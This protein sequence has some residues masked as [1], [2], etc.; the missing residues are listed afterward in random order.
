MRMSVVDPARKRLSL[1]QTTLRARMHRTPLSLCRRAA[2]IDPAVFESEG[3]VQLILAFLDAAGVE[4]FVTFLAEVG[5]TR[6]STARWV[7]QDD[8]LWSRMLWTHFQPTATTT[9]VGCH[10]IRAAEWSRVAGRSRCETHQRKKRVMEER[11]QL[12]GGG[13]GSLALF[14]EWC[15]EREWFDQHVDIIKGD[16]VPTSSRRLESAFGG[17]GM[18]MVEMI[19]WREHASLNRPTNASVASNSTQRRHL[20]HVTDTHTAVHSPLG[21]LCRSFRDALAVIQRDM[22]LNVAVVVPTTAMTD[23]TASTRRQAGDAAEHTAARGLREIQRFALEHDWNGRI[24]VVCY[25]EARFQDFMREKD[26]LLD[27]FGSVH[28]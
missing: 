3:V 7:F 28:W 20:I 19:W 6:R 15:Y 11:L 2:T 1:N 22:E 16:T 25:E 23:P 12:A 14:L 24:G 10:A 17:G 9:F 13:C 21:S 4:S 5:A 18:P 27:S 26:A 8:V